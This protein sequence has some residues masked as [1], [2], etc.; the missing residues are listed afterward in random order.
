MAGKGQIME[1]LSGLKSLDVSLE[2]MGSHWRM[3]IRRVT[4]SYFSFRQIM[5]IALNMI[6]GGKLGRGKIRRWLKYSRQE[7]IKF[8]KETK[9]LGIEREK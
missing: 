4:W 5:T 7:R 8:L 3:L 1:D 2:A 9:T 6:L